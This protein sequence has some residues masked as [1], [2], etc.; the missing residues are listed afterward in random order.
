VRYVSTILPYSG[1]VSQPV[2]KLTT[3][4]DYLRINGSEEPS[5][6]EATGRLCRGDGRYVRAENPAVA[7]W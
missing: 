5:C 3:A 4:H 1:E 7:P 2:W 6:A